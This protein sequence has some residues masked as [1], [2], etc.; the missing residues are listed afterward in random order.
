MSCC[1][2]VTLVIRTWF[3]VVY[4]IV[5]KILERTHGQWIYRIKDGAT[6][7]A[8]IT[9]RETVRL[10]AISVTA[11]CISLMIGCASIILYSMFSWIFLPTIAEAQYPLHFSTADPAEGPVA[12]ATLP[13][14]VLHPDNVPYTFSTRINLPE[15]RLNEEIGMIEFNM[16]IF[17]EEGKF[18]E[19]GKVLRSEVRSMTL[20]FRSKLLQWIRTLCFAIPLMLGFMDE[21]QSHVLTIID[22]Y[23]DS[24]VFPAKTIKVQMT[25]RGVQWYGSTLCI[26]PRLTGIRYFFYYWYAT[27][28]IITMSIIFVIGWVIAI[29]LIGLWFITRK[30]PLDDVDPLAREDVS[31]ILLRRS[32]KTRQVNEKNEFDKNQRKGDQKEENEKEEEHVKPVDDCAGKIAEENE[33]KSPT[34]RKSKCEKMEE[35]T[36]DTAPKEAGS[37]EVDCKKNQ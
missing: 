1:G 26:V 22:D 13:R 28:S 17:G 10:I 34:L 8:Y 24:S 9:K 36:D 23:V 21:S 11:V 27:S 7:A 6:K 12:T 32:H 5:C 33:Q 19:V 4:W 14:G 31:Q 3:N 30:D 25:P 35:A 20:H 2:L 15:S 16:T 37:F 18:G 29:I